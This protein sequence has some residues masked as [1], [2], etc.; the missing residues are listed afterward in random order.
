MANYNKVILMGN[1]TRD[2]QMS[3]LPSQTPV[4]EFGLAVNRRWRGQD[5]Q[6]R[7]ETCFVDCR[8]FGK[9]A[10]VFNQYMSKGRGVLVEGRLHFDTWEGKD[11]VKR[12]KHRVIVERFAFIGGAPGGAGRQQG[13]P[14]Q[15]AAPAGVQEQAPPQAQETE[16]PA[17]PA[18]D[19]GGEEIPF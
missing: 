18:E 7:E 17:P 5:N 9:Q 4:V 1:L 14:R 15:A 13:A 11:G 10:E 2:P 8:I 3:Y 16:E 12:S 6:Q 19:V